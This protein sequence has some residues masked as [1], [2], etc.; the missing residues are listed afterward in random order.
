MSS[1]AAGAPLAVWIAADLE[2]SRFIT[3]HVAAILERQNFLMKVPLRSP[4]S[5]RKLV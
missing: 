5:Q 1:T 3:L 2:T 4:Q